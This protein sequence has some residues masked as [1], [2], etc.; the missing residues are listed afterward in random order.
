MFINKNIWLSEKEVIDLIT[1]IDQNSKSQL[2]F[3]FSLLSSPLEYNDFLLYKGFYISKNNLREDFGF[4]KNKL[5]GDFDL[6]I[7]PFN[8]D[9]IF[10]ERALVVEVKVVRPTRLKPKKNANSLGI[11]QIIGLIED[12]FP[13]ISIMHVVMTEPLLED[14]KIKL[15]CLE[16]SN[17]KDKN[18]DYKD[19]DKYYK[20]VKFDHF[21]WVSC[22]T[23]MKRLIM[24]D[25]PK[26]IGI[27]SLSLAC[28]NSNSITISF[29]SERLRNFTSG[30]FNPHMKEATIE[31]IKKHF[32]N[33][34]EKYE[35]QYL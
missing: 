35:K 15:K 32:E 31:K 2:S 12:G 10:F 26:Y 3:N 18:I 8:E 16:N 9:K 11:N 33:Y 30:Y 1:R 28:K 29:P 17:F 20:E 6:I 23:Q 27:E 34:R 22:D 13:L 5:P 21:G 24:S 25:L 7:L 19:L 14:E 4:S